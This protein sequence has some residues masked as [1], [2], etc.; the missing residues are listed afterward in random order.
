[1][2]DEVRNASGRVDGIFDPREMIRQITYLLFVRA[3]PAG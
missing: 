2:I 3:R 1:M